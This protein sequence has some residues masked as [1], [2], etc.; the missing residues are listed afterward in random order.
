MV[1]TSDSL[2]LAALE[3]FVHVGPVDA[4]PEDLIALQAE[5]PVG[6]SSNLLAT[7]KLSKEWRFHTDLSQ[8][9]GDAW[10]K[11]Q[12][13]LAVRVPSVLIDVEWNVLINPKHSHASQIKIVQTRPFRFDPRMFSGRI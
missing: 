2:A 9:T 7:K 8:R 6:L 10:A 5:V 1:Y 3:L 11:S 12:Q 13:S 4:A